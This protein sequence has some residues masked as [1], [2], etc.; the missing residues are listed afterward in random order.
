MSNHQLHILVAEDNAVNQEVARQMLQKRGYEV[1][2]ASNGREAVDLMTDSPEF[3]LILMDIQM[4]EMDGFQATAAIREIEKG[5]TSRIPIVA[6]TAHAMKGD[7]ERCLQAG[8]DGYVSKPVQSKVL[9]ETIEEIIAARPPRAV[10]STH[11]REESLSSGS[12]I[13]VD[14]LLDRIG[15]SMSLLPSV[16]SMFEEDHPR[17]LLQIRHAIDSMDA[18]TLF[19]AAHKLKGSLLVL[20]ADRAGT[21]ALNLELMGRESRLEGADELL[22]S[23]EA[24]LVNVTAELQKI[25]RERVSVAT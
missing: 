13:N 1:T 3:D 18:A 15:G 25:L 6:M 21:M 16:V 12:V 7:R 23:L 14:E 5:G 4:P 20:A 17:Q 24:E 11:S 22:S 8:M 2:I 10:T 9:Y 19:S